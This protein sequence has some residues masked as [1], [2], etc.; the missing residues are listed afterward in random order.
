[1]IARIFFLVVSGTIVTLNIVVTICV[2]LFEISCHWGRPFREGVRIEG[3]SGDAWSYYCNSP[4][5]ELPLLI[6]A[7]LV[8]LLMLALKKRVVC[9]EINLVAVF[10]FWLSLSG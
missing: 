2:T 4:V 9:R 8:L 6:A 7:T 5:F 1:M 10:L 3:W